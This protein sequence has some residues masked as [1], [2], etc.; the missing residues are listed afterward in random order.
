MG[1]EQNPALFNDLAIAS[2]NSKKFK[3]ARAAFV[4]AEK[5][6]PESP[7]ICLN[8]ARFYDF[9]LNQKSESIGRYRRFM[10]LTENLPDYRGQRESVAARMAQLNKKRR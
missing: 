4:R 3:E 2:A 6:A 5:Y 10:T 7:E 9:C 1:N 8:A